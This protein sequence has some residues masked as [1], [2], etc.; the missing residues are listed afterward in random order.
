MII[1]MKTLENLKIIL[2]VAAVILI[3]MVLKTRENHAWKGKVSEAAGMISLRTCFINPAELQKINK[4]VTLILLGDIKP[5]GI[6][7]AY[8]FIHVNPGDLV[9]KSLIKKIRNSDNYYAIVS[10]S[11]AEAVKAWVILSQLGLKNIGILDKKGIE[12]EVFKYQ[13]RPDSTFRPELKNSEE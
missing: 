1:L 3:G 5:G 2:I 13:F 7:E 6:P 8:P 4:P 11:H 12:N 9:K 10:G